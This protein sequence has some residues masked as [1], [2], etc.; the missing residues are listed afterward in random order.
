MTTAYRITHRTD[1]SYEKPVSSSYGQLHMLPRELP[2]QRC[3]SASVD[4]NPH[5]ELYR[6]RIDFFGNRAG[7]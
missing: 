7:T 4:V 5:P 1:Y 6:E 3:I 2:T